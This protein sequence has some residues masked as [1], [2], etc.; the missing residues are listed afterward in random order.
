MALIPEHVMRKTLDATTMLAK[1][2]LNLPLQRHFKSRYPQLNRNRLRERYSTDTFFSSVPAIL[3]GTTCAQIFVG[4]HSTYTAVYP[5][6]NES[7]GPD[8]LETFITNVE[9]PYHLMNDNAK[10][11]TSEAWNKIL[12]KYNISS[13]TTEPYHP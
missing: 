9:A 6:R 3:T 2:Y 7:H 10:M 5:M 4:S 1:N 8:I 11:Q 12:R 13:S